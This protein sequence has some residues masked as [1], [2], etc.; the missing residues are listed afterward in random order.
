MHHRAARALSMASRLQ[1]HP[2]DNE[3]IATV[4]RHHGDAAHT[5]IR[6]T[7]SP[8]ACALSLSLSLCLFTHSFVCLP[9]QP[10]RVFHNHNALVSAPPQPPES[11][12]RCDQLWMAAVSSRAGPSPAAGR[13]LGIGEDFQDYTIITAR[14][15]RA[16]RVGK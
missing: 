16:T 5:L 1:P 12:L 4:M 6:A 13:F 11:P 2:A 3:T 9:Q 15:P 8:R 14:K 10:L 7:G